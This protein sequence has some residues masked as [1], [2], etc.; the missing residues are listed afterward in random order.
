MWN[1]Y[2]HSCEEL[3]VATF[4]VKC[5]G[6]L[7]MPGCAVQSYQEWKDGFKTE[8]VGIQSEFLKV[9]CKVL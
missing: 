7:G 6:K 8:S 2:K 3:Q 5:N 4:A 9:D 1:A